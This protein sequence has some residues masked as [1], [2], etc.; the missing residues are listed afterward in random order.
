RTP[1]ARVEPLAV[2]PPWAHA[3][4]GGN[5][6]PADAAVVKLPSY[7]FQRETYWREADRLRRRR[8]G[9][10]IHPLLGE[11]SDATQP[12][13]NVQLDTADLGYLAD[14]RVKNA[15]VFPG[16]GYVEMALAAAREIFGPVPSVIED[17][18]FQKM[19]VIDENAA[20]PVQVVLDTSSSEFSVYARAE[21]SDT[22]WDLHARGS[23]RPLA[24][25]APVGVDLVEI[26]RRCS[27]SF[28]RDEFFRFFADMGF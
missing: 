16:A 6:S 22:G 9:E 4:Q 23:V 20:R 24:Q 28:D 15:I 10:I 11:R 25:P 8:L 18:E 5:F 13:W 14:H 7:P 12:C 3:T 1:P 27:E 21:D 19:L 17:I 2:F 26:R